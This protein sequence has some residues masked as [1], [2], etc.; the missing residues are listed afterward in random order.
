MRTRSRHKVAHLT[1]KFFLGLGTLVI[2]LICAGAVMFQMTGWGD[3]QYLFGPLNRYVLGV[4]S[5]VA[6][7]AG[8]ML[9]NDAWVLRGV[10]KG[11]YESPTHDALVHA[12]QALY[13]VYL[14]KSERKGETKEEDE[15]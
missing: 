13:H 9:L 4:G 7:I 12:Y 3:A 8:A 15:S 2:G 1:V 14:S 10:M 5:F 11:K 6:I